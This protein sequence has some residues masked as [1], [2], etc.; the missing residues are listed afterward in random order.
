MCPYK[1]HHPFRKRIA[2]LMTKQQL[3]EQWASL[4]A[5]KVLSEFELG[6]SQAADLADIIV[7]SIA[8][9]ASGDPGDL[10][11][12]ALATDEPRAEGGIK[13]IHCNGKGTETQHYD[14]EQGGWSDPDVP[15]QTCMGTGLI[16]TVEQY[17]K[18]L[19]ANWH[20]DSSVQTWF[21]I[22]NE[23]VERLR[24]AEQSSSEEFVRY[25]NCLY[26]ANGRLIQMGQEPEK[27]EYSSEKSTAND[28]PCPELCS[29]DDS[30]HCT[31]E[32]FEK[33]RQVRAWAKRQVERATVRT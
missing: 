33:G 24:R 20:E 15:C 8:E 18:T 27:L 22:L 12:R 5:S 17:L 14:E 21:P 2:D 10:L 23:E 1:P 31:E 29:H 3:V 11:S 25:R 28:D 9:M 32:C 6:D 4:V 30:S 13:C 7:T 19:P 16:R 26:R